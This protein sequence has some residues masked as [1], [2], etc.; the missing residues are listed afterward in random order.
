M[1]KD[2]FEKI[3]E[4]QNY[5]LEDYNKFI[6]IMID[7]SKDHRSHKNFISFINKKDNILIWKFLYN[8]ENWD[9]EDFHS[10]KLTFHKN[11]IVS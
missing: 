10:S 4:A 8:Q 6:S 11:A 3:L 5:S 1:N 7:T 9:L 2:K